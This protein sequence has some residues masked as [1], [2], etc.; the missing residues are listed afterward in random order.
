MIPRVASLSDSCASDAVF[1]KKLMLLDIMGVQLKSPSI[2]LIPYN[3]VMIEGFR[4]ALN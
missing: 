3:V 2:L 1:S 4:R